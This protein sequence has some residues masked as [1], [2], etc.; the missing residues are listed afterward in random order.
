MAGN[1]ET[2]WI[3]WRPER[4]PDS[5]ADLRRSGEV[6]AIRPGSE[7]LLYPSWQFDDAGRP[8][9]VVARLVSAARER[10]IDERRLY[11]VLTMQTGLTARRRTFE[12]MRNGGEAHALAV[13]RAAAG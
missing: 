11:E 1:A 9:P 8:L 3:A 5:L 13:V 10:G 6:L 12:L 2:S 7:D 4:A